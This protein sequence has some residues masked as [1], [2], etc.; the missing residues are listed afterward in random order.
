MDLWRRRREER[1]PVD[2]AG[3]GVS[4]GFELTDA[5]LI[6]HA[7]HG[8]SISTSAILRPAGLAEPAMTNAVYGEADD[9]RLPEWD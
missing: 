4:E 3:G 1:P 2:E 7:S 5:D 8:N 9:E 6:E